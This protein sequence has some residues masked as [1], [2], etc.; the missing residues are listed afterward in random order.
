MPFCLP[1]V[2]LQEL[3][4]TSGE[5]RR[6]LGGV[7]DSLTPR[8]GDPGGLGHHCHCVCDPGPGLPMRLPV[9]G[10]QLLLRTGLA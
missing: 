4:G 9:G 5:L 10:R 6:P 3:Q 7:G 8:G 1:C 2:S